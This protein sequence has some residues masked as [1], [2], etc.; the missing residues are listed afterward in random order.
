MSTG[1]AKSKDDVTIPGRLESIEELLG[2]AHAALSRMQP[3]ED[4]AGVEAAGGVEASVA[5]VQGGLRE[6][7]GRINGIAD[8]VGQL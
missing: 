2:S 4:S 5:R 8:T 3:R 6:L 1:E 7:L